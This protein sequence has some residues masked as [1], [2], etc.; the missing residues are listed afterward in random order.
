MTEA[1][2]STRRK[3]FQSVTLRHTSH[4]EDGSP[5]MTDRRVTA[6]FDYGVL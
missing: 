1:N 2:R 5:A 6:F 4:I 3:T